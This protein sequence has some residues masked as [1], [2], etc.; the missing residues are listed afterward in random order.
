LLR[1]E[2]DMIIRSSIISKFLNQGYEE[3]QRRVAMF[4]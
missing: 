4:F 3:K 1:P 2:K